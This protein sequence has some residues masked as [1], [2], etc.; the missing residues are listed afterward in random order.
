MNRIR[1]TAVPY[2]IESQSCSDFSASIAADITAAQVTN[3]DTA[4]SWRDHASAGYLTSVSRDAPGTIGSTTPASGAFTSLSASNGL[5]VSAGTINLQP[6]G[7]SGTG[8]QVLTSDGSGNATWQSIPSSPSNMPVSTHT[9][10]T[11]TVLTTDSTL[12]ALAADVEFTLPTAASVGNGKTFYFYE[13]DSLY[14]ITITPSGGDTLYSGNTST[15]GSITG[16][17]NALFVSDG[18][19]GWYQL[20]N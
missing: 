17:L 6:G 14:S 2:A 13:T 18:V 20:L 1:L 16:I 12:I 4:Y 15:T 11:Y 3:W 5:S 8:G 9:A 10:A 19:D 7:S